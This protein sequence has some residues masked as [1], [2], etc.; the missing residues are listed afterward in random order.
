MGF[1]TKNNQTIINVDTKFN[2]SD[3]KM[4]FCRDY[5]VHTVTN[6]MLYGL[7]PARVCLANSSSLNQ[8]NLSPDNTPRNPHMYYIKNKW[9]N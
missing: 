3:I 9:N 8:K 7:R 1:L 6:L 5:S 2:F 4:N